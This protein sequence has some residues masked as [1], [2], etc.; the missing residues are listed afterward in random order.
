VG[1]LVS[2][3]AMNMYGA[4]WSQMRNNLQAGPGRLT[5]MSR[6]VGAVGDIAN[7][8]E[9]IRANPPGGE[10]RLSTRIPG[11]A[12]PAADPM[13]E[14]LAVGIDAVPEVVMKKTAD[15]MEEWPM[16]RATKRKDATPAQRI[17]R[18]IDQ[19][20]NN[21][22]YLHDEMKPEIRA[23][24]KQW[25]DGARK[26]TV[27]WSREFGVEPR[28]VAG[29]IAALSPQNPWY[30]NMSQAERVMR[31]MK[32]QGRFKPDEKMVAEGDRI[33]KNDRLKTAWSGVKGKTLDE[34]ETDYEKALW[35]RAYDQSHNP[36]QMRLWT[37]EG[38]LGDWV[39]TAGG[40]R[41]VPAW[42]DTGSIAKAISIYR[43]GSPANISKR[44]GN[45]H[46]VRNFYNNIVS[47]MSD[48]GEVTIDTHAVAAALMSPLGASSKEVGHALGGGPSNL[49]QGISGSY[50]MF[51]EAYRRAA[52]ERGVLPREL[53]SITWE[54]VRTIFD[55][56]TARVK[57]DVESVWKKYK[58]GKL[59]LSQSREKINEITGGA[60]DPDWSRPST[61]VHGE[62]VTSTYQES[63]P[64]T[65][66]SRGS[67]GADAGGTGGADSTDSE[68]ELYN[69]VLTKKDIDGREYDEV[70]QTTNSRDQ[71]ETVRNLKEGASSGMDH[72]SFKVVPIN[73]NAA[74]PVEEYAFSKMMSERDKQ[75]NLE[76]MPPTADDTSEVVMYG[77][78]EGNNSTEED[79]AT[80]FQERLAELATE[81]PDDSW[82]TKALTKAAADMASDK[83]LLRSAKDVAG[84]GTDS[85]LYE[86]VWDRIQ[87]IIESH[88]SREQP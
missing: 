32:E 4:T 69:V 43:D 83:M 54:E 75:Y 35:I 20:T 12:K 34:L 80:Y 11:G 33:Y 49:P 60:T 71:A 66:V 61:G 28:Q 30:T 14:Y 84:L 15:Q 24:A 55:K 27:K 41:A 37:P 45:A 29:I 73:K 68:V 86:R 46:K 39:T 1:E 22:L 36:R 58:N 51:A 53:Q 79:V 40:S 76:D 16:F 38:E 19:M 7:L 57:K 72:V 65:G 6:Q 25:Y 78:V 2:P 3:N 9:R 64:G 17:E 67:T 50:W 31:T 74:E 88:I 70:I 18:M 5:P 13:A 52:K 47:P 87:D 23:R 82:A 56:K 44:L 62:K 77:L 63:V 21:L 85:P 42:G 59:T 81:Y 48:K 8:N 10:D 26:Q